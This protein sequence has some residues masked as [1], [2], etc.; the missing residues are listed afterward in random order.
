M[1]VSDINIPNLLG[2]VAQTVSIL[3]VSQCSS[4]NECKIAGFWNEKLKEG[5]N[6]KTKRNIIYNKVDSSFIFH[7]ALAVHLNL[8]I[9]DG[10]KVLKL[11]LVSSLLFL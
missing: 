8:L 9:H 10:F 7:C 4:S 5:R 2:L 3:S 6:I 1:Y 11:Q